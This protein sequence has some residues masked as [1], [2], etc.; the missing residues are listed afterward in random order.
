MQPQNTC[1]ITKI[2]N[3][4]SELFQ[5]EQPLRFWKLACPKGEL[6]LVFP[7]G[8]DALESLSNILQRGLQPTMVAA[9]LTTK[10]GEAKYS[11]LHTLRHFYASWCRLGFD[12]DQCSKIVRN[13]EH[14]RQSSK[15]RAGART[16][17]GSRSHRQAGRGQNGAQQCPLWVKSGH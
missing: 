17:S 15:R 3:R 1:A 14:P 9:G 8:T 2:R 10:K 7:T 5:R 16:P 6:G 4:K 11:G 13:T 12:V